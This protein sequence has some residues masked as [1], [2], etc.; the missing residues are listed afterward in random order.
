MRR[1]LVLLAVAL[2]LICITS[3]DNDNDEG[4]FSIYDPYFHPTEDFYLMIEFYKDLSWDS[5]GVYLNV[6]SKSELHSL[7]LGQ[8]T[9]MPDYVSYNASLKY[10]SYSFDWGGTIGDYDQD[11]DYSLF[12]MDKTVTGSLRVPSEYFCDLPP[13][14]SEQDLSLSWVLNHNPQEQHASVS[15]RTADNNYIHFSPKLKPAHRSLT[16]S[17]ATW[18]QF[19]EVTEGDVFLVSYNYEYKDGGLV[20]ISSSF[21]DEFGDWKG[22]Q[23]NRPRFADL[24]LSGQIQPLK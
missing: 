3:C 9:L 21:E 17:E 16:L 18:N 19:E 15:F 22:K 10:N 4:I 20:L 6:M 12:F 7:S 2:C 1:V 14:D 23:A 24:L 5:M 13:F 8:V 11:L